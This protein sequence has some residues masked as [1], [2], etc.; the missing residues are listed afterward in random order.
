MRRRPSPLLALLL[1]SAVLLTIMGLILMGAYAYLTRRPELATVTP[2]E[3]WPPVGAEEIVPPLALRTLAGEPETATIQAALSVGELDTA[4][5]TLLFSPSVGDAARA[6]HLLLLA[7]RYVADGQ[8]GKAVACL[9]QVQ[10]LV[11]LSPLLS[12]VARADAAL[13]AASIWQSLGHEDD[14]RL[15]LAQAEVVA[16]H[17]PHLRPAQR[18]E[19]WQRVA[20]AY[21][22]LRDEEK[23]A[24]AR[25]AADA[26]HRQTS[27][28]P[29]ELLLPGFLAELPPS[30]E[31]E[32]LRAARRQRAATLIE[33]W[34]ALEGGDV[35]PEVADLAEFLRREDKA[36]LAYFDQVAETSPQLA[37]QAA[38]AWERAKWLSLKYRIARRGFGLSI[39]PEWEENAPLIR[40]ELNKAYETLFHL[41]GD[42]ATALPYAADVDRAWVESLRAEILLG[43]LKL[44][45][46]YPEDQLVERLQEAQGRLRAAQGGYRVAFYVKDEKRIFT[47]QGVSGE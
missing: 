46:D 7:Q 30:E 23:A 17:S 29:P 15:S 42:E 13:Q 25:R 6:G 14:A 41:Y 1:I 3:T 28:P 11:V 24:A 44:Y 8:G 18:G 4:Y 10:V 22:A 5:A 20:E 47:L 38:A 34:I 35:G 12:D 2:R 45:P 33:Q 40:L 26:A 37:V 31:I 32:K 36:R 39:L 19:L 21:A 43:Q 16:A 9:Q 27:Q